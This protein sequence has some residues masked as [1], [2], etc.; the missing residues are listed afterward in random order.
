MKKIFNF[1]IEGNPA[2]GFDTGLKAQA[3][4]QAKLAQTISRPGTIIFPDGKIEIWQPAAVT[5]LAST[6]DGNMVIWGPA[7]PGEL[8]IEVINAPD[9]Q[10]EALD[11]V[12]FWLRARLILEDNPGEEASFP[13]PAG[14]MIITSASGAYPVGTVFFPPA[15]LVKRVLDMETKAVGLDALRYNHPDMEITV[16]AF[17]QEKNPDAIAFCAGAMLYRI[18]CG[19]DPFTAIDADTLRQDMREAV[20][21]PPHLA[22]P[23]LNP[24]MSALITAA[25]IPI[26]KKPAAVPRD[27]VSMKS[28]GKEEIKRPSPE[29]IRDFLGSPYTRDY[30]SWFTSLGNDEVAAIKTERDVF[31]KKN[32]RKVHTRRFVIRNRN[33]IF[34]ALGLVVAVIFGI[35]SYIDHQAHLPHTRGMT[36]MEVVE[37]YYHSMGELDHM[38]MEACV[39]GRVGRADIDTVI[40]IFV[41]IRQRQAQE[42]DYYYISAARWDEAGRPERL[43]NVFGVTDLITRV[44]SETEDLVVIQ[45]D[46]VLWLP[47]MVT[48]DFIQV[49]DGLPEPI[50]HVSRPTYIF[51]RDIMELSWRGDSWRITNIDRREF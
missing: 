20:Y 29:H 8:L 9:R 41:T 21:T 38:L 18:L 43:I 2:L 22:A 51:F 25:M 11:L 31:N 1:E 34:I 19:T 24:E 40:N 37:T 27:K 4:A 28:A 35:R 6:V 5:E 16:W 48:V 3:F 12:R 50:Y 45:A 44:L 13:G 46:F 14:A 15:R 42:P 33:Y 39:V 7:F 30:S 32:L 10:K 49:P 23:G 26:P 36:P 47:G 17:S